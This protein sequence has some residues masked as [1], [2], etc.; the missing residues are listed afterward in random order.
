MVDKI[1][2]SQKYR[3]A[4]GVCVSAPLVPVMVD[5]PEQSGQRVILAHGA[6]SAMD[7]VLLNGVT[8]NLVQ[9]GVCVVRFEFPYMAARRADKTMRR[10]PDPT[11]VL[12]D[13]WRAVFAQQRGPGKTLVGGHSM[14]GRMASMVADEL[15]A[16][17]LCCMAY[18]WHPPAKP[19]QLRT[20]HLA[21]LRTPAVM[22]CGTRDEFGSPD[23]VGAY[24][25]SPAVR[26]H[27]LADADHSFRSRKASGRTVADN[28]R[29]AA[30]V[31]VELLGGG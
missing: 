19:T 27:W 23:E 22:V 29:D 9:H 18:P 20:A 11:A 28:L 26:V 21:G 6:G 30:D 25:F 13:T 2:R 17:A 31:M 15:G 16:H 14:G 24:A 4:A 12:L 7:S 10:P 1:A 8:R 3:H 5:G